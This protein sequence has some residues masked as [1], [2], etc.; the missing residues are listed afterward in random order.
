MPN[1]LNL[2]AKRG[3]TF[4]HYYVSYPL[5]CPSRVSLL[6]GRYSHNNGVRGN[7]QPNGGYFGFS[8]RA[9][10]THNLAVWL[11]N[12]GYRTIHVGKFLNGYGDEPFDD[13]TAVPPGWNA[14]H[15]VQKAD[16]THYFYGYTLND[17]GQ[18]DGPFGDSGSWDTRE[19]GVRDDIGC[20]FA[21]TNGLPC[22]YETDTLTSI[23][24]RGA[25]GNL[26]GT[27]L[28]PAA[29]LH[30]PPRR[31]PPPGRAGAGAAPLQL[32]Q[33][34]SPASPA[35]PGL[36]R[37]QRRRQA[38]L[39]PRSSLPLA[40]RH[41]HLPRLLRQGARVAA[42][43]RRR[44][45]AG[46]RHPGLA[47]PPAQHL[48][49]LHL[50]QRLLL[51]RAPPDRRQVPRLRAVHAPSLPDPRAAHPPRHR[52][53]RAGGEHRHRPDRARAGR[54]GSRQEHRR[55]LDGAVPARPRPAHAAPVP[56]RVLRRNLRR[57]GTGRDRRTRR[58][59]RQDVGQ[60]AER[61]RL[62]P[63][64]AEGL[65]GD[66]PRPLQVHRLAGRREGALRPRKGPLRAQQHRPH[67]QLLPD[68]QLPP[69]GT[70]EPARGLRRPQLHAK[71]PR[72]SR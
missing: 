56:L 20:P 62:D 11:Q 18:I 57:R 66:P 48:R 49:H 2:I 16:T 39:H 44:R 6:T 27:A 1:T 8:F 14:W 55:A 53:R 17:N 4:N 28:L 46:D 58:P 23:A 22:N 19:Y 10:Y 25:A 21:P 64:P 72:K 9:A 47:A 38:P 65:R 40:Q 13:G 33:R 5:C 71:K 35:L 7:V 37:G 31:L 30:R 26:A 3:E 70:A 32:V 50:R 43:D 68:P 59:E 52:I 51:R 24:S 41:P 34:R 60:R 67:P 12:D 54:R 61:D 45:Q 29:R 36:R 15:T 42:L 63:R 69:P